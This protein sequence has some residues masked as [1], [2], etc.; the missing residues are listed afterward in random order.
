MEG[1]RGVYSDDDD[2]D[3]CRQIPA[4]AAAVPILEP[5]ISRVEGVVVPPKPKPK[6]TRIEFTL[7]DAET[8]QRLVQKGHS[9]AI[10]YCID[11]GEG[12]YKLRKPAPVKAKTRVSLDESPEV[13]RVC[14][15]Y[16]KALTEAG[17]YKQFS[18]RLKADAKSQKFIELGAAKFAVIMGKFAE[19]LILSRMTEF[20]KL[21]MTTEW[22]ILD[23]SAKN[24]IRSRAISLARSKSAAEWKEGFVSI[25]SS[26]N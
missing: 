10:G 15:Y 6:N 18:E 17:A 23:E 25:R 14:E 16:G 19:N 4:A 13:I 24:E 22:L 7:V 11:A 5:P 9:Y 20:K 12:L 21:E 3:V 2:D 1:G 8:F 26:L